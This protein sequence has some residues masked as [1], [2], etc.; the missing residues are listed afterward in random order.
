MWGFGSGVMRD[1]ARI[2]ALLFL[3]TRAR[4]VQWFDARII[5]HQQ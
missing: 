4:R 2:S 5:A 1:D 3:L